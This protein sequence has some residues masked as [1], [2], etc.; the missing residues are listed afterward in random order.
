MQLPAPLRAH[1]VQGAQYEKTGSLLL[2]AASLLVGVAIASPD[3]FARAINGVSGVLWMVGAAFLVAALRQEPRFWMRL[4]L[5]AVVGMMLVL[6]VRPSDLLMAT[7]GFGSAGGAIAA[8]TGARG[9]VWAR[10]LAALWLPEHLLTAVV[11]AVYRA[12]RDVPATLR[13]EPPPT[14]ALVPFAMVAAAYAGGWLVARLREQRSQ[15]R[16]QPGA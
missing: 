11:R 9:F 2:V 5:V 6:V 16:G 12:A 14:A 13:S 10:L 15:A 8:V 1:F 7:I 3:P 4:G